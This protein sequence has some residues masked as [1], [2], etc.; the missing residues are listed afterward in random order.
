M[1]AQNGPQP[2]DSTERRINALTALQDIS[3]TLTSELDLN[4]LL[5]KIVHAAVE[6]LDA[7]TG[8]LLIWDPTDN[9]LVFAVAEGGEGKGET[10]EQQRMP[11]D[12]GIAG[13]IFTH[14][15]P[16]IVEDVSQDERF[17]KGIDESLG[18]RTSS[19]VGAPLMTPKERIGVIEVLNKRSGEKFDEQ[20]LDTLSA[21]AGQA[22]IA[23]VNARLYSQIREERD[24]MLGV[25]EE[26]HKKLARDFHDGPA[27]TLASMIMDIEFI[28]KLLE[29]EPSKVKAELLQVKEK[30]I[31]AMHQA[32][33]TMFELRPLVLE[34]EG[35]KA[36]LEY[37]V[38]QL[39]KTENM[40]IHLQIEGLEERL[41]HRVE[42][43]IFAIVREAI[44]NIKKHSRANN[45]WLTVIRDEKKL[46]TTIR[47]DGQGFNVE[48]VE[49]SYATRGSIGLLNL[50]ERAEMLGG[51]IS[52]ESAPGQGTTV[53]LMVL[54]SSIMTT[55]FC[56]RAA[57][58]PS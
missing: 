12:Q 2:R 46:L 3:R 27:Q 5:R 8:S 15:Q 52:I 49:I 39:R 41:P 57:G 18:Y 31:K 35:L 33:T 11:V 54:L 56:K 28:Q 6:V 17:F 37:Y 13:W 26:V 55:Q 53:S 43:T 16:V 34:T 10:L 14:R 30:A 47:D 42:D 36:G 22:A 44:N 51:R 19:L 45:V 7:S 38:E 21:L 20:D 40:S 48:E 58:P 32:R 9:S 50:Y 23:I 24:R 29:R 1:V 4:R 25:E